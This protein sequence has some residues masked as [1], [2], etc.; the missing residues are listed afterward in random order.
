MSIERGYRFGFAALIILMLVGALLSPTVLAEEI[1]GKWRFELQI[2]GVDPGDSIRSTAD[3]VMTIRTLDGRDTQFEDPRPN[4]LATQETSQSSD[5]RFDARLGYGFAAWKNSELFIDVGL[6]YY[7]TFLEDIEIAYSLDR[8][9][10]QYYGSIRELNLRFGDPVG[11]KSDRFIGTGA[12]DWEGLRIDGGKLKMIPISANFLLRFRPTKRMNPYIGGGVGYYFVDFTPTAAWNAFADQM[13]ASCVSYATMNGSFLSRKLVHDPERVAHPAPS[14]GDYESNAEFYSGTVPDGFDMSDRCN[15]VSFRALVPKDLFPNPNFDPDLPEDP[16]SNPKLINLP[17]AGT[18]VP[19]EWQDFGEDLK[20][21]RIDTPNSLFLEL[22]F[23][24]EWQWRPK[25]SFF[26]EVKFTWAQDGI[27]ITVDD[28]QEF[29]K[30]IPS[31]FWEQ[32]D[33]PIV[34]GGEVAYITVGGLVLPAGP[35]D[36][37]TGQQQVRP[38]PGEYFVNG[39]RLDYGGFNFSIGVRFTL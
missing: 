1:N 4:S 11:F 10:P 3:R 16:V 13:D 17:N 38:Q 36:P 29:G 20:R 2:G 19:V 27:K 12:E 34:A 7:T 5:T 15:R 39:G 33:A 26:T 30:G 9:D 32:A 23:G 21:P 37:F 14:Q 24:T 25:T 35:V 22:R 8:N 28:K 18:V 6:G 31:G